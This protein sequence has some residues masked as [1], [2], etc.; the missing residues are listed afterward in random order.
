M[1]AKDRDYGYGLA[2]KLAREQLAQTDIAGQCRRSGARLLP[3]RKAVAVDFLDQT[4]HISLPDGLVTQGD[5]EAPVRE[6]I[7]VLHYFLQARGTPLTGDPITFKEL[8]EGSGYY[9]TFYQR[10]IKP[11]VSRFGGKQEEMVKVAEKLNGRPAGYGDASVTID[12][13]KK[14]P[15]TFVL[16]RGDDEFPPEGSI[17]FDRSIS[18]YLPTE[19]ITAIC[20]IISSRLINAAGEAV[21]KL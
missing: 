1:E 13:F 8:P 14:V 3:D 15:I 18:D 19:D 16:W 4:F 6:T 20:Q 10:A 2:V 21:A 7:L 17:L 12:A 11:L 5:K 9:P